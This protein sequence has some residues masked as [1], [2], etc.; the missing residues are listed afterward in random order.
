LRARYIRPD[1][2]EP[3]AFVVDPN[4]DM[5][6]AAVPVITDQGVAVWAVHHPVPAAEGS[7]AAEVRYIAAAGADVFELARSP[8]PYMMRAA[9]VQ[10]RS[11]DLLV[12]GMEYVENRFAFSLLLKHRIQC[13]STT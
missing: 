12:S 13:R 5:W 10:P 2:T 7:R 4:V 8:S 6:S 11:G 1:A 9:A 3:P